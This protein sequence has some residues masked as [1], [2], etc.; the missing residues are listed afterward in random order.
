[1]SSGVWVLA[2]QDSATD[3]RIWRLPGRPPA[4]RPRLSAGTHATP[5]CRREELG[6]PQACTPRNTEALSQPVPLP[7][8]PPQPLPSSQTLQVM[9]PQ[10]PSLT[11]PHPPCQHPGPRPPTESPQSPGWPPL[12]P[13]PSPPALCPQPTASPS[14]C[15]LRQSQ[16]SVTH[17]KQ[18]RAPGVRMEGV[19]AHCWGGARGGFSINPPE[20]KPSLKFAR[21][22]LHVGLRAAS[23][24]ESVSLSLTAGTFLRLQGQT[25]SQALQS[26]QKGLLPVS[27]P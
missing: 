25:R 12:C 14:C 17:P 21:E 22:T 4:P 10:P 18:M 19:S 1:M 11:A 2:A 9:P 16:A 26:V 8:P 3:T 7:G 15:S 24:K 13:R 5:F 27:A 20:C 6:L 23:D